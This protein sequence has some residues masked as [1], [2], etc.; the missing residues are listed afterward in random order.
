MLEE[1]G[2]KRCG[3]TWIDINAP[4]LR[5][6]LIVTVSMEGYIPEFE[7]D[8]REANTKGGLGVY[9]GDKLEGLAAI[10]IRNAFGCM[11]MY[12]KRLVQQIRN[13]R[14]EIDYREVSYDQQPVT[15]LPDEDRQ[16]IKLE[17]WGIN[18]ENPLDEVRHAAEVFCT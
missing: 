12:D 14:Q 9:F 8:A 7:G 10:G 4:L 13:G 3:A 1:L 5:Y 18:T 11:P 16:P 17:V 2:V 15:P 6:K